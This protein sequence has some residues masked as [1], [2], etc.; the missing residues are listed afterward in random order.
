LRS[1][2]THGRGSSSIFECI[3]HE[4]CD[5]AYQEIFIAKRHGFTINVNEED[6]SV[7]LSRGIIQLNHIRDDLLECHRSEGMASGPRLRLGDLRTKSGST[8]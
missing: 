1:A 7:G 2:D 8:L 6:N 4:I 5:R 3:I